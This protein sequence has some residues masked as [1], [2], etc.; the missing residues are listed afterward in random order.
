[1][2]TRILG[3]SGLEVS[4]IGLGCMGFSHAYGAPTEKNEAIRQ[5]QNAVD[6]GYTFFDTAECYV[7]KFAD[8]AVSNNE[9][10]I[11]E[12]LK[13][14]GSRIIIATKFGV[15]LQSG[16][17][18]RPVSDS[19]PEIIRSSV[20]GSLK[21]LGRECID[22]Y[23]QHRVDPDISA[24]EVAGVM[25]AL[26]KEG[27]IAH[28]GVSE[29][30]EAYIRR[31]HAVCPLTAIQNRYS[32][33]ARHHETLFPTLEELN[34]GYVAFSP[35]A[36]GFLTGKY[37][38]NSTFEPGNDYRTVMPQFSA[39]GVEKNG[40]LLTLLNRI[41]ESKS[42]TP[43]QISLAWMLCKKPWIVPIPGSRKAERM[44]ENAGAA[45]ITLTA[46]EVQSLDDALDTM[47]MSEVFGGI[48]GERYVRQ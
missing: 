27:K 5:I 10:L 25:S 37:D 48:K 9:A 8:G 6:M 28:W 39:E 4:A 42:A 41:A 40:E 43:A 38:A 34:I 3:S 16:T 12:A 20:E 45:N 2:Q 26:I 31:A 29:A 22:L 17:I 46:N 32:M 11:G 19:R 14:Y 18:G 15:R 30:S 13:P 47:P 21:R 36:N 44:K 7:G 35:I 23:Y 24:E 1:M 33:M